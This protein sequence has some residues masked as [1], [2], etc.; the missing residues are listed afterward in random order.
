MQFKEIID[1]IKGV[2]FNLVRAEDPYYFE[3]VIL[4]DKLSLLAER[5]ERLFGKPVFPSNKK[6]AVYVDIEKAVEDFGGVRLGQTLYFLE[7]KSCCY[8]AM[9]WPWS[10]DRSITVKI[11]RK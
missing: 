3:A 10:D 4:K 8:F 7:E 9:F 11:G 2:G 6:P 1:D 5:L